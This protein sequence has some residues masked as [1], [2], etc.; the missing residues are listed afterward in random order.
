MSSAEVIKKFRLQLCLNRAE[1]AKAL[2]ITTSSVSCYE[3][4]RRQPSF[5]TVRKLILLAKK[6]N[7]KLKL[8]DIRP[9]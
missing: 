9:E 3:T 5:A 7:I 6:N 2:N 4:G 8:E 1:L